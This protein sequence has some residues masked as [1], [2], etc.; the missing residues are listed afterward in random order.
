MNPNTLEWEHYQDPQVPDE[1]LLQEFKGY[2]AQGDFARALDLLQRNSLQGKKFVSESIMKIANGTRSLQQTFDSSVNG[3]IDGLSNDL[4]SL[5]RQISDKGDWASSTQYELYNCVKYQ[6][7]MYMAVDNPP[8]GTLPT[9]ATHWLKLGLKGD[10]GAPGTDVIMK[11]NWASDITYNKKDLVI[12]QNNIYVALKQNSGVVPGTDGYTWILFIT[13][14]E[15]GIYVGNTAPILAVQNTIW[16]K[17][18][19]NPTSATTPLSGQFIRQSLS[20]QQI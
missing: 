2:I 5:I 9:D 19:V 16:F 14:T 1:V 18:K 6:T 17:T 20:P 3:Y 13:T 12:Y 11:F 15:G 8:V 4:D 10:Q 7:D